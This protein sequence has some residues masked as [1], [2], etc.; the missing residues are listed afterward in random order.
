MEHIYELLTE[1]YQKQQWDN[2]FCCLAKAKAGWPDLRLAGK[3]ICPYSSIQKSTDSQGECSF[4]FDFLVWIVYYCLPWCFFP[5][6]FL[7][8]CSTWQTNFP[9][10]TAALMSLDIMSCNDWTRILHKQIWKRAWKKVMMGNSPEYFL[11]FLDSD[12]S[13]G[14]CVL[15]IDW[16]VNGFTFYARLIK[17]LSFTAARQ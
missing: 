16:T 4:C 17:Y 6:F 7:L 8:F 9:S 1:L 5:P 15:I 2:I 13:W 12:E 3:T 10:G 14:H 11:F